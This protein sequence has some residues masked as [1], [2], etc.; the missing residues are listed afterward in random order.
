MSRL[1]STRINRDGDFIFKDPWGLSQQYLPRASISCKFRFS[2]RSRRI[3]S[4]LRIQFELNVVEVSWPHVWTTNNEMTD[5]M[6]IIIDRVMMTDRQS[7]PL[8]TTK[9]RISPVATGGSAIDID[10][11]DVP[12]SWSYRYY[13]IS[14]ILYLY[15]LLFPSFL[16]FFFLS[17]RYPPRYFLFTPHKRSPGTVFLYIF[18]IKND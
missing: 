4:R 18:S 16:R 3:A 7:A 11:D 15:H 8:E 2:R 6:T 13:F 5:R 10:H 1:S 17:K 14:V 12:S 9:R